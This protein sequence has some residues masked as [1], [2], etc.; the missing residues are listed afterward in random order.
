[1]HINNLTASSS[2]PIQINQNDLSILQPDNRQLGGAYTGGLELESLNEQPDANRC[3][4]ID[5]PRLLGGMQGGINSFKWEV[6]RSTV[7]LRSDLT[8]NESVT[9]EL[10]NNNGTVIEW[11]FANVSDGNVKE[12]RGIYIPSW[13]RS[14][15]AQKGTSVFMVP[16]K[17]TPGMNAVNGL[18]YVEQT[19]YHGIT[20]PAGVSTSDDNFNFLKS[21]QLVSPTEV[22][23]TCEYREPRSYEEGSE[24]V[25]Q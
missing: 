18:F 23:F 3:P 15:T 10:K 16:K 6:V 1:M 19:G 7:P 22:V 13:N 5:R 9:V 14:C 25:L 20:I 21:V 2:A 12:I 11:Q 4:R 17:Y 8:R 24:C